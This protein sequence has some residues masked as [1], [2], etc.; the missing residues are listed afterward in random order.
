MEIEDR[1][2][3][4]GPYTTYDDSDDDCVLSLRFFGSSLES[5]WETEKEMK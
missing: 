2:K 4:F 5:K 1:S 3:H